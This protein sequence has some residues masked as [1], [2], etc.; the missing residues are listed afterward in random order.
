MD[1]WADLRKDYSQYLTWL[2]PEEGCE[3]EV[4]DAEVIAETNEEPLGDRTFDTIEDTLRYP[5]ELFYACYWASQELIYRNDDDQVD[6]N[7]GAIFG[8]AWN[9]PGMYF[10]S[11]V[12]MNFLFNFGFIYQDIKW[13]FALTDREEDWFYRNMFV[14]GDIYMRFFYRSLASAPLELNGLTFANNPYYDD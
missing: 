11:E 4:D 13:L 5:F 1:D 8:A 2:C 10:I 3:T 9:K 12:V 6:L 14:I 7:M